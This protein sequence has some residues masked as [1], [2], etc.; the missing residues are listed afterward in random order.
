MCH[1]KVK[2]GKTIVTQMREIDFRHQK[3]KPLFK[4][5]EYAGLKPFLPKLLIYDIAD[6]K[7]YNEES[8]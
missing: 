7:A 3:S 8:P 6:S 1:Y 4:C 5:N 2:K